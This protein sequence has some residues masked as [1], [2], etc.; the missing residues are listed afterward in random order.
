[1]VTLLM[2]IRKTKTVA[3]TVDAYGDYRNQTVWKVE[4][5]KFELI[6]E[7]SQCE[8]ARLYRMVTLYLRMKPLEHEFKV[9]GMAPYAKDKYSDA[10]VEVFLKSYCSLME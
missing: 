8:I 4:N 7:S 6:S 3:I 9:M 5:D 10:V 2:L 1:M